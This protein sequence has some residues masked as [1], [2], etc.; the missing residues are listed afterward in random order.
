MMKK[1]SILKIALWGAGNDTGASSQFL[2]S[3]ALGE[4]SDEMNWPLDPSDFGRCYR[5]MQLLSLEEAAS[6]LNTAAGVSDQW[7]IV[8]TNWDE[9]CDL[10]IEE[11]DGVAAPKLYARMKALDL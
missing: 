5:F 10:F 7:K 6:A 2:A 3:C 4:P 1:S 9:L 11:R 8:E